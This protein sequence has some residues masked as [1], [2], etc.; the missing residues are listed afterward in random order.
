MRSRTFWQDTGERAVKTLAQNLA[1]AV[2]VA[3]VGTTLW[4]FDWGYSVGVALMATAYSVLS[5]IAS[6]GSSES[7]SLAPAVRHAKE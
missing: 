1:A 6:A 7:A 5:S 2:S 4:D 3:A